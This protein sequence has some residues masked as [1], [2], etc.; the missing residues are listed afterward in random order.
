MG[1]KYYG[2][3]KW[4][5]NISDE[6][7]SCVVDLEKFNNYIK[8]DQQVLPKKKICKQC[9]KEFTK[10]FTTTYDYCSQDCVK[11]KSK[12]ANRENRIKR[13]R[14]MELC[15]ER[16]YESTITKRYQAY[17]RGAENRDLIF[18][19]TIDEF[20]QHYQKDCYYCGDHIK[21]IGLDRIDNNIGYTKDNVIPCCTMCNFMKH[22][23][24]SSKFVNQCI[25][26]AKNIK[27]TKG[28]LKLEL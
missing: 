22:H 10:N 15:P 6:L 17:K 21:T 26:I 3:T 23:H 19:L 20:K 24:S 11:E 4:N 27:L 1:K 2:Q 9:G 25:K 5:L 18:N 7:V 14:D 16:Y 13:K 28:T 8:S 12:K